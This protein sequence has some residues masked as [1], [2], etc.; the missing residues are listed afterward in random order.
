MKADKLLTV[1]EF[2]DIDS[3]NSKIKSI[4]SC[5]CKELYIPLVGEFNAGKT[6]LVNSLLQSCKL[7]CSN[8]PT[9]STIFQIRFG[10]SN[11]SAKIIKTTGEVVD[12]QDMKELSNNDIYDNVSMVYINDTSTLVPSNIVLVDSPG[13]SSNFYEHTQAIANF[14]PHADA[15]FVLVDANTGGI[16][17]SLKEFLRVSK[18]VDKPRYLIFTKE[19]IL[20]SEAICSLKENTIGLNEFKQ[21]ISVDAV[22]GKLDEFYQLIS[23]VIKD[24]DAILENSKKNKLDLIRIQ[25]IGYLKDYIQALSSG[26]I[27]NPSNVETELNLLKENI[28]LV[29]K[30]IA[31]KIEASEEDAKENFSKEITTKL[32][33]IIKNKS[34]NYNIAAKNA[35]DDTARL[36]LN[37]YRHNIQYCLK[38]I[39]TSILKWEDSDEFI[40]IV[41]EISKM[42]LSE[43]PSIDLMFDIDLNSIGHEHDVVI[44]KGVK[45]LAAA[46]FAF[47]AVYS[48]GAT[49]G[50]LIANIDPIAD[51]ADTVT[52]VVSIQSNKNTVEKIS[53]TVENARSFLDKATSEY[54]N[55]EEGNTRYGSQLGA[56]KGLVEIIVGKVA[57]SMSRPQRE[58]AIKEYVETVLAP[59]FN[60]QIEQIHMRILEE[61]NVLML[62][63]AQ[64]VINNK[65]KL[66]E[67]VKKQWEDRSA[68]KAQAQKYLNDLII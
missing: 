4:S 25:L 26:N 52:D 37:K 46:G 60:R 55:I 36:E 23:I 42:D 49:A 44:S 12:I 53:R 19:S 7:P 40:N 28:K 32:D 54:N 50:P 31:T 15:L 14:I 62:N 11:P 6:S 9:T 8:K 39:L 51:V 22:S 30:N 56:D 64:D 65:N 3:I 45:L 17:Q 20:P 13:I 16:T 24:K 21:V 66:L 18:A 35:I 48:S 59:S 41:S 5:V 43:I 67:T 38:N 58:K 33:S 10:K 47:A 2:L 68:K 27:Q 1:S 63:K 61:I 57:E 34:G 29:L